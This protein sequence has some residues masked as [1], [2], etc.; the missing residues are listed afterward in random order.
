MKVLVLI[1][2]VTVCIVGLSRAAPQR[3]QEDI[4]QRA[5]LQALLS[6]MVK[7]AV[8]QENTQL[9]HKEEDAQE[10]WCV[11]FRSP[12]PCARPGQRGNGFD[13]DMDL[14]EKQQEQQEN[15]MVQDDF[16]S[17]VAEYLLQQKMKQ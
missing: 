13:Y 7:E 16:L 15:A 9:Q 11:C 5:L 4:D 2:L 10:E 3:W 14:N 12:C 6:S 17:A 8:K 1:A